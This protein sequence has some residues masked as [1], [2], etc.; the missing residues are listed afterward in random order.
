[1]QIRAAHTIMATRNFDIADI[2]K[3]T[4]DFDEQ[5]MI[6]KGAYSSVYKVNLMNTD[7]AAKVYVSI[8]IWC[9]V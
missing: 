5:Y 7:F 3:A 4:N 1:M 9:S 2:L 6:A 8:S